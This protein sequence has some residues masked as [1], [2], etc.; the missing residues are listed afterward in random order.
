MAH[1]AHEAHEEW[2]SRPQEQR[3]RPILMKTHF[4]RT[5]LSL[6]SLAMVDGFR[7]VSDGLFWRAKM[8]RRE[9]SITW[10]IGG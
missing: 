3:F 4:F 7:T 1:E 2:P 8:K 10:S 9:G 6:T 5:L